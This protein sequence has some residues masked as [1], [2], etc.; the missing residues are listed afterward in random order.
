MMVLIGLLIEFIKKLNNKFMKKLIQKFKNWKP[1]HLCWLFQK[2]GWKIPKYLIGS[3]SSSSSSLSSSSSSTS[4]S[5]TSSSSTS[6]YASPLDVT[7]GKETPATGDGLKW[8][9]LRDD[10]GGTPSI[11]GDDYGSLRLNVDDVGETEVIGIDDVSIKNI[12]LTR[13]DSVGYFWPF[14]RGDTTSF[15]SNNVSKLWEYYGGTMSEDWKYIQARLVGKMK[16]LVGIRA[17]MDFILYCAWSDQNPKYSNWSAWWAGAD[18]QGALN[19]N[20]ISDVDNDWI[21]PGTAAMAMIG[22]MQGIEYLKDADID[23]TVYESVVDDFFDTWL[24]TNNQAQYVAGDD[25]G[26]Y[27]VEVIYDGTGTFTSLG[28]VSGAVTGQMMTAMWAYKLFLTN[29]G[30]TTK[31]TNWVNNCWTIFQNAADYLVNLFDNYNGTDINMMPAST[32]NND[33]W[34]HAAAHGKVGLEYAVIWGGLKSA[35]VSDYTRIAAA[36]GTGMA[37]YKDTGTTKNYYKVRVWDTDHY[38]AN[39]YDTCFDQL[40]FAPHQ[41]GAVAIDSFAEDI[42]DWWTDGDVTYN[43]TWQIND[44]SD[45]RFY[46]TRWHWYFTPNDDTDKLYPGPGFQLAIVEAKIYNSASNNDYRT[47]ALNRFIWG[48]SKNYANLWWKRNRLKES[49]FSNGFQ[50]WRDGDDLTPAETWARFCDTSS[51]YIQLLL[52]LEGE[53]FNY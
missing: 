48:T 53:T 49:T 44:I 4:S 40:C 41:F 43:M 26:G 24:R 28:S 36:L 25:S 30:E 7:W 5:S 21:E 16:T 22:F 52:L 31:A 1:I 10:D 27:A 11:T 39:S 38:N 6:H 32:T 33:C 2:Y 19:S 3:S 50:D 47:R 37:T 29:I 14:I 34:I 12:T 51:Y 20:R 9:N 18:I 42:S 46:G 13:N 23:T 8:T 35:T 15:V 17:E 45:W